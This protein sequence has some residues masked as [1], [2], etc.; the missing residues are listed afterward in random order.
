M[1][2]QTS[3]TSLIFEQNCFNDRSSDPDQAAAG[4]PQVESL[5]SQ[6]STSKPWIASLGPAEGQNQLAVMS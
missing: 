4:K 2:S 5:D 1:G 6:A 3:G